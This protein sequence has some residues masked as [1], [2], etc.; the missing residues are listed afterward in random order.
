MPRF[1][2]QQ[3]EILTLAAAMISGYAEHPA[4]F[5]NADLPLLQS[6]IDAYKTASAAR[7][8]TAAKVKLATEAKQAAFRRLDAV[9]R[10]QLKQAAID[11]V[12][13]PENLK[14]IG[15]GPRGTKLPMEQPG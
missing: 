14:Y 3:D 7:N 13:D 8:A 9:I 10:I 1:P 6:V 12:D 4:L 11:T 15:W 5:P 2:T